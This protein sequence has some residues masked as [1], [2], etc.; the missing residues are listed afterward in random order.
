MT[1]VFK[2]RRTITALYAIT[3]MTALGAYLRTDLSGAIAMV[4][5]SLAG[6]NSAQAVFSKGDK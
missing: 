1:S 5:I 4:A 3:L 2:C 6:A